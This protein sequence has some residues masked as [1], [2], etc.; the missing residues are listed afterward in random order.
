MSTPTIKV[1]ALDDVEWW[2][3]ESLEACLAVARAQ[4]GGECY[5]EEDEQSEV[6]PEAMQ[7]LQFIDEDG[8]KRSFAEQL[9]REIVAGTAFP[10][11]FAATE[12]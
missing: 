11:M 12:Y 8:T 3:G 2:A 9:Q 1:F 7:R 6:G 10:C 5:R 4:A